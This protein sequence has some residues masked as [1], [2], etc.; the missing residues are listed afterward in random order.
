MLKHESSAE[1]VARYLGLDVAVKEVLFSDEYDGACL[2][3]AILG[4]V[5]VSCRRS[6][7]ILPPRMHLDEVSK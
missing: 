3:E 2:I 7:Q 1:A 6:R 4:R 5:D